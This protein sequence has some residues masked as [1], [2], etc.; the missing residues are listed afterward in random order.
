MVM[1]HKILSFLLALAVAQA[2]VPTSHVGWRQLHHIGI[3]PNEQRPVAKR[4]VIASQR[5][6][7]RKTTRDG[8]G[9][10]MPG[11]SM[12]VVWIPNQANKNFVVEP[13]MP[14]DVKTI[15]E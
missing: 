1:S 4:H 3:R 8:I 6:P 7:S 11:V 2:W 10:M 14:S 12:D 15:R 9:C 13:V 5:F